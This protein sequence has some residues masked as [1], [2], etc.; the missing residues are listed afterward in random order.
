MERLGQRLADH[1]LIGLDTCVFIYHV[2]AHPHYLPLTEQLLSGIQAGRQAA[3]TSTV[4]VME[5]TVRPWQVGRPAVA[6]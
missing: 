5:L 4:M 3:I 2:E 6:R 1:A